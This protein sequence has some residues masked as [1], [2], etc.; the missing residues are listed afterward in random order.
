MTQ[1]ANASQGSHQ[2]LEMPDM[3]QEKIVIRRPN[4]FSMAL[5][6][7]VLGPMHQISQENVKVRDK[8][9]CMEAEFL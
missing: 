4:L 1:F 2:A 3:G 8:V 9:R 6:P 7:R 5:M